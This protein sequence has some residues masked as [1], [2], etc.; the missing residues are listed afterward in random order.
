VK[1]L[2]INGWSISGI[3]VGG[4][5]SNIVGNYIGTDSTG[6]TPVGNGYGVE[7]RGANPVTI[8]G[9]AAGARNVIS[10]NNFAGVYVLGGSRSL[11]QGNY[12]GTDVTG[13]A[14][15]GNG[16]GIALSESPSVD[17]SSIT[18]GGL[19]G[20][21]RNVISGNQF[22]GINISFGSSTVTS[23]LV[24]GN[25]I[26][27]NAAGTAALGNGSG[28]TLSG[29]LNTTIG[30]TAAGAR[31]VISGN[32]DYALSISASTTLVQGNYV[33]T[34]SSGTTG[35]GNGSGIIIPS[36]SNNLIGGTAAGA[37]NVISAN[38]GPGILIAG[39]TTTRVQGNYV[40]IDTA[41]AAP[42]GNGQGVVVTG[43]SNT[44]V[45]GAAASA[46]NVISGN[47]SEG[48]YLAAGGVVVQ[49]NYV[50]TDA[51]GAAPLG[52]GVGVTIAAGSNTVLGG[53]TPGARNVISANTAD[54]VDILAGSTASVLAGNYIGT[55]ATG[56]APVGN[57][58]RG[59]VVSG[60]S[61]NVIGGRTPAARNV[62]SGN[63]TDGVLIA[64]AAAT[65]NSVEGNY[66]GTNAAGTAALG[67]GGS[68]V[69][70]SGPNNAVGGTAAG[71]RNL[72]SGNAGDGVVVFGGTGNVIEGNYVGT[73]AAGTAAL[74]NGLNGVDIVG[75]GASNNAVGGTAAG[76]GNIVAF[77]GNDGVL[78][79]GGTG[80][81]IRRNAIFEHTTGLGIELLNDGNNSQGPPAVLWATSD[82]TST[83]IQGTLSGTPFTSYTVEFFADTAANPS[84]FGEGERLLGS[85]RATTDATGN[86]G[87]LVTFAVGVPPGQF[88]SATATDP[89]NNTSGFARSLDWAAGT[90]DTGASPQAVAV[91]DFNGDGIPD[92]AVVNTLGNSVSILLGNGD[93]TFRPRVDYAVGPT[94]RS[95]AVADFNGDGIPDLAVAN[96]GGDSVS[97]LL[98]NGD[99]SFRP[100]VDYATG[101]FPVSVAV[102]DVNG[103][104]TPDLV[105]ANA[106]GDSVSVLLGVGDGTFGPKVDYAAGPAPTSDLRGGGG[107]QRRRP[108]RPG[109]GQLHQRRRREHPPGPRRRH[110]R[111]PGGLRR[112]PRT[113]LRGGGG[114]QRRR[115][116]R[117]GRGRLRGRQRQRAAGQRG[118]HL[119]AT[120]GLR[121]RARPDRGGGSGLQRRRPARPGRVPLQRRER[122][123]GQRQR[124]LPA[125]SGLRPRRPRPL[126]RAGGGGPQPRRQARPGPG[127]RR[128]EPGGRSAR[129][130]GR[131]LPHA[132]RR[133]RR[134]ARAGAGGPAP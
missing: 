128:P 55:D 14:P 121:H 33:G 98:G 76:A 18:I 37:R 62:I 99:G 45:G 57:G 53:T 28:I 22:D 51:S 50:G 11:I 47:T 67:N 83:T 78:V 86:A 117:P 79:D 71:A 34:D 84:G 19:T 21:A 93:G 89:E 69:A 119:R 103:D 41:G 127:Q 102:A 70:V 82:G 81:A 31:N 58:S 131:H 9:T 66:L 32:A 94:P 25:Y 100:R 65:L 96:S 12:I 26:G 101:P 72:I 107:L 56:A 122:A 114:L 87:F 1:G 80:N 43:G 115:P 73:N 44:A 13:T 120:C 68:G 110:L 40:G 129:Q 134:A 132:P 35:L 116:A 4:F 95:V 7:V 113:L 118:R 23:D 49:G 52:N 105:T 20:G 85:A 109:R 64:G 24:Q 77:N 60:S 106:L 38:A 92:L 10:G 42:L 17:S 124:H 8:G 2:V 90:F 104:G 88:I 15:L 5:G 63:G 3:L 39:G 111:A 59:V 48:L 16:T 75:P 30:G 36:G 29:G 91:G 108:A 123:A 54:G 112:R 6:T 125:P 74:G 27:T 126:L 61:S 97:V 46:R 130:R 133:A